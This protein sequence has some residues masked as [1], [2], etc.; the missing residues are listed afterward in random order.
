MTKPPCPGCGNTRTAV[1]DSQRRTGGV[2]RRSR[3]CHKCGLTFATYGLEFESCD[4]RA[5]A[6]RAV[7]VGQKH[8]GAI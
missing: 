4:L 3:Y 2:I 7:V 6:T 1:K 8:M 5:A